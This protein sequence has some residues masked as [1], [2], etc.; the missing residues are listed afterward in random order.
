[1]GAPKPAGP[2]YGQLQQAAK[3]A[4][5][6]TLEAQK[7]VQQYFKQRTNRYLNMNE[8]AQGRLDRAFGTS[9]AD[10]VKAMN[11]T[12]YPGMQKVTNQYQSLLTQEPKLLGTA[13]FNDLTNVL[14]QS[15]G[16]YGQAVTTASQMAGDRLYKTLGAPSAVSEDLATS[17]AANNL[18]NST[19][20]DVA[21]RPPTIRS[22]VESMKNLYTYDADMTPYQIK[23]FS[24]R[25]FNV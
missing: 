6:E 25:G 17:T 1:M 12:Y 19:F 10:Y 13:S 22:D 8:A 15:A 14:R 7:Q 21:K 16:E 18:L 11:E 23:Q 4:V 5:D 9:G 3:Q 24:I 2:N 20:M